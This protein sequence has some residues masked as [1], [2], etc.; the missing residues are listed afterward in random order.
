MEGHGEACEN[1]YDADEI[2]GRRDDNRYREEEVGDSFKYQRDEEVDV[3]RER[4]DDEDDGQV[5]MSLG[6]LLILVKFIQEILSR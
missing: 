4:H 5:L 2:V 3:G 1:Q 6:L